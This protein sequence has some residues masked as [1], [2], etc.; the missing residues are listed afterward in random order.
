MSL[1]VNYANQEIPSGAVIGRARG[2][3]P[4]T[5]VNKKDVRVVFYALQSWNP[6]CEVLTVLSSKLSS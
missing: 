3:A 6:R 2:H 4:Y 5:A 1:M